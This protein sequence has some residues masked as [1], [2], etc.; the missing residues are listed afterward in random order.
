MGIRLISV[1]GAECTGKSTLCEQLACAIPALSVP[2]YLRHWCEATGRTPRE[3]EQRAISVGHQAAEQSALAQAA[4]GRYHWIVSDAGPLMTAIYSQS[5]F[6]DDSL[7]VQAIAHQ[8]EYA[9][10]LLCEA[11]LPWQADGIQRDGPAR[12]TQVQESLKDA[13]TRY[14]IPFTRIQGA[15]E[16]RLSTALAAVQSTDAVTSRQR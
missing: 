1:L 5:Y 4:E 14:Q 2:E 3:H 12:Q 9:L 10:T 6:G 16:A 7:L 13:L 11:D 15:A 8:R